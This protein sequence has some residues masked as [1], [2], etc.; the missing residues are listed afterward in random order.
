[1]INSFSERDWKKTNFLFELLNIE[2]CLLSFLLTKLG[3]ITCVFNLEPD[4][5]FLLYS[6]LETLR[7]TLIAYITRQQEV[8][9]SSSNI[10]SVQSRSSQLSLT[11]YLLFKVQF[12][13]LSG[14]QYTDSV[15]RIIKS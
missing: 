3:S 10:K 5:N 7:C 2:P 4:I 6:L 11:T 15:S 14:G 9:I 13:M 1:V 8:F 12:H